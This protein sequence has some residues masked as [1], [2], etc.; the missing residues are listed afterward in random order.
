MAIVAPSLL[1][2]PTGAV[3]RLE[4]P[5]RPYTMAEVDAADDEGSEWWEADERCDGEWPSSK[6]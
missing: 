2:P 4:R 6:S 1:R 3:L 5:G